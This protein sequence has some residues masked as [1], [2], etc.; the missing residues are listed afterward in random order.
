MLRFFCFITVSTSLLFHNCF[1]FASVSS[2]FPLH[3]YFITVSTSLLFHHRFNFTSIL[4]LF[5]IH[6]CFITVSTSL[7]FH[8]CFHCT[9]VSS[10][11]QLHFLTSFRAL[12]LFF[13][14]L[15]IHLRLLLSANCNIYL[16]H[17]NTLFSILS[18][19]V[20]ATCTHSLITFNIL[21]VLPASPKSIRVL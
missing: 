11:L 15:T 3:F 14:L 7:L 12:L 5:Q 13:S 9:S 6:F 21:D 17:F 19:T 1:H 18:R 8:H 2:L 16:C 20:C 4:S 10:L